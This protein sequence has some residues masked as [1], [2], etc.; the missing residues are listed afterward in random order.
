MVFLGLFESGEQLIDIVAVHDDLVEAECRE[1]GLKKKINF[2]LDLLSSQ[3]DER[4]LLCAFRAIWVL[5][6]LVRAATW[7]FFFALSRRCKANR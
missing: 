4:P 2:F 3:I 6:S 5:S 1:T 7:Y